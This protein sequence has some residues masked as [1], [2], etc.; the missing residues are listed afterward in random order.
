[1]VQEGSSANDL[2]TNVWNPLKIKNHLYLQPA[3]FQWATSLAD[4][5]H[6]LKSIHS[7]NQPTPYLVQTNLKKKYHINVRLTP[8]LTLAYRTDAENVSNP[9]IL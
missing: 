1:M 2:T 4:M 9:V 6:K 8:A 7:M 3:R 5:K